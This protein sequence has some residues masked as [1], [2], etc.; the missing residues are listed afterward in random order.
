MHGQ[1][2]YNLQKKKKQVD[3]GVR[4]LSYLIVKVVF[5]AKWGKTS[6]ARYR[7]SNCTCI[8]GVSVNVLQ[9]EQ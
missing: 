2:N 6:N 3:D 4:K 1:K 8:V 9:G 5:S 7:L